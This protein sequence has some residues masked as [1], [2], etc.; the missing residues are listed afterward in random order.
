MAGWKDLLGTLSPVFKIGLNK[1][2]IDTTL[3]TTPKTF[4][5]PDQSGT[6]ALTSQL[7]GGASATKGTET[8]T[9][10]PND[11]VS[12]VTVAAPTILS[13]SVVMASVSNTASF[14][15]SAD[16]HMIEQ[17]D[18]KVTNIIAG[19]SFDL[20]LVARSKSGLSGSYNVNYLL[21]V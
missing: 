10:A 17:M 20:A 8:I 16:E 15:H 7:G 19:V 4:S 9:C 13:N 1:A 2:T 21:N 11:D 3:I 6:L 14:S 18:V 5:L 12:K